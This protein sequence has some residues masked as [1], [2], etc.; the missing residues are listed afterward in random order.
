M[1]E[2]PLSALATS[3]PSAWAGSSQSKLL[4]TSDSCKRR[5]VAKRPLPSYTQRLLRQLRLKLSTASHRP[6]ALDLAVVICTYNGERRLPQVLD[7]LLAQLGTE[8]LAWEVIV[9]D[10]NSTDGTAQ[11]VKTYQQ[12]W[13]QDVPLRYAFEPRQG[14]GYARQHAIEI[15]RSP[16]V[17]FLDDDNHPALGW[18]VAAHRFG[19]AHPQAGAFGSRI[20]GDFEI[21]PPPNF[22]RIGAML[23]LTERGSEPLIYDPQQKILPPAAGLVVRRQAWLASVPEQLT[24]ADAIGFRAAGED[25]EVV[26]YMQRHGW[27]VWY[28]P[29]MRMQHQIP[30]SRFERDYLL[31]LFRGIGLSRHHTRMLSVARW[32]GPLMTLLYMANDLRKIV[33]HLV[34]YRGEA[35]ADTVAACELTLYVYSLLSPFY[36]ARRRQ[37]Q[38]YGAQSGD[39]PC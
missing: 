19:Q 14:A 2:S 1:A 20:R 18:V 11:V 21:P 38:R 15:A 16:L 37:R 35:I 8:H 39:V 17:G 36:L 32:L 6:E 25:L 27:E 31:R 34:R 12:Q 22:D 7:C 3:A 33:R 26:L 23:A 13:P 28:N 10:N 4:T 30:A 29:A 5:A 24:L 9:V